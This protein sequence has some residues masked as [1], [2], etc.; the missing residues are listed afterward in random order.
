MPKPLEE[1]DSLERQL[2]AAC[3]ELERRLR[4]GE[5]VHV[6]TLIE[7]SP[8]LGSHADCTIELIYTEYVIR[9]ELGQHP[10]PDEYYCR[11]PLWRD[12]LQRQFQIHKLLSDDQEADAAL[13]LEIAS[14]P[15]PAPTMDDYEIL[16]RIGQGAMGVVYKVLDRQL[17]RVVALKKIRETATPTELARFREEA[18]KMA[19]LEHPHIVRVYA[20]GKENGLPFFSMELATGGNLSQ[21]IAG[22]PQ[23]PEWAA[24][25]L[26]TLARAM[27]YAHQQNLIHRDLKPSNVVL[28]A[29]GEPKITDFGLAKTLESW[30][31]QAGE[32]RVAGT[33][34]VPSPA[35]RTVLSDTVDLS[36]AE[37]SAAPA[38]TVSGTVLGTPAYMAPEQATGNSKEIGPR[39]DVYALGAILYEMLTGRPPFQ[40]HSPLYIL[41]QVQEED[42]KP[43]RSWNPKVDVELEAVCLKALEKK[44]AWRYDSADALAEDL[45]RWQRGERTRA[46]PQRW[47]GS[48]RRMTRRPLFRK[49]AAALLIAG[50]TYGATV[51][52]GVIYQPKPPPNPEEEA[53]RQEEEKRKAIVEDLRAGKPVTLID[54]DGRPLLQFPWRTN[55]ATSKIF[56][57]PDGFFSIQSWRTGLLELLPDPQIE[58]YRFKIEVRHQGNTDA[59]HG[60][61]GLYF[62]CNNFSS[63][64]GLEHCYLML[65]FND[66]FDQTKLEN[67]F[68]KTGNHIVFKFQGYCEPNMFTGSVWALEPQE[69]SPGAI[70]LNSEGW[71]EVCVEVAPQKVRVYWDKNCIAIYDIDRSSLDSRRKTFLEKSKIPAE[72]Q[73]EFGPRGSLGLYVHRS[74]ASFR[75]V[76]V[77]P[78]VVG[79]D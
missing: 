21:R 50:L 24:Q 23:P 19:R 52:L 43:P 31:S 69:F 48:I 67:L 58:K 12:R 2:R 9:E 4:A 45:R 28:T 41:K 3:A 8:A 42:P 32:G 65:A 7:K 57:T 63:A 39:T 22:K 33:F 64:R 62:S 73:P 60:L 44:P 6:E 78:L 36:P 54:N 49:I 56:Q 76:M 71:R 1:G 38:V 51:A 11:F 34:P 16:G 66:L 37:A 74:S 47:I 26:E 25:C 10:T 79:D 68:T 15:K 61:V 59:V 77:E 70:G 55:D 72:I 20:V 75:R 14:L 5:N 29:A 35:H 40:G 30:E 53:A 27:H 13:P 17:N 18:E 46:R